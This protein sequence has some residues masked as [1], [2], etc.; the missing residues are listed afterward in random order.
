MVDVIVPIFNSEKYLKKCIESILN[1]SYRDINVILV[2]DGSTDESGIICDEFALQDK[3]VQVIHKENQ[4]LV[5]ARKTGISMSNG[6]YILFVDSDDWI[7][8]D[9]VLSLVT[10]AESNEADVVISGAFYEYENDALYIRND[11][12]DGFY[13]GED[14]ERQKE[15]LYNCQDYFTMLVLPYLWNKLWKRTILIDRLM[16]VDSEITIGEDV[17]IGFPAILK[18]KSLAVTNHGYY[19]YR[20]TVNSMLHKH[21]N[22]EIEV[23]NLKRLYHSLINVP[24]IAQNNLILSAMNR[25]FVHML[26]IRVYYKICEEFSPSGLFGFLQYID[27]PVIIYG[28][29]VFGQS[30]YEYAFKTFS[31]KAWID[32]DAARLKKSGL[33]VSTLREVVFSGDEKILICVFNNNTAQKIET[34]L[35]EA[36]AE[37]KQI[38]RFFLT[39][40]EENTVL[41]CLK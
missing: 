25:Y 4:G 29:G 38:C 41:K 19:H 3:R 26:L 32:R 18:A 5:A 14:L 31:V 22:F 13:T 39:E 37:K 2:D 16:Q 20:Q 35:L 27:R 1:Q 36:G 24:E 12:Q 11:I 40:E 34:S 15:K 21:D 8:S 17:A 23:L 6:N 30:V 9:M 28:A 7:D 10:M 33:P